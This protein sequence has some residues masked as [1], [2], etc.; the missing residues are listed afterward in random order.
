METLGVGD[1]DNSD[2]TV[3]I[4]YLIGLLSDPYSIRTSEDKRDEPKVSTYGMS[5]PQF[6]NKFLDT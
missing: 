6:R 4:P 2:L 5:N 3:M 1:L